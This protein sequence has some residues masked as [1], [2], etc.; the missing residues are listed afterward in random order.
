ASE[1][2]N[3][4]N[5]NT[6]IDGSFSRFQDVF[7][8]AKKAKMKVRGYVST[9]FYCPY[10]GKIKPEQV[11][12]VVDRLLEIGC[13]EISIGDTLGKAIT[14]DVEKLF[15][16]LL[17]KYKPS[18]FAGHFHDTYGNAIQNVLKS[19]EMGIKTFDSSTGGIGGCPYAPG[20]KGNVSTN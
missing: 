13:Y 17:K 6:S 11:L 1:T 3:Q 16:S 8:L 9:S 5:I 19:F 12:P 7:P 10:E 2:F 18:Q 15:E 14:G 20:A 4:K